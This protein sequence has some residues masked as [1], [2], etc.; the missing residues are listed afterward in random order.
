M[1]ANMTDDLG[2]KT[3][4]VKVKKMPLFRPNFA[5]RRRISDAGPF[6]LNKPFVEIFPWERKSF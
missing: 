1:R 3:E 4:G 2:S 6:C 5:L